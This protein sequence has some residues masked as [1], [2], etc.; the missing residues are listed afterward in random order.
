ML[1]KTK[2]LKVGITDETIESILEYINNAV[3]NREKITIVTPNPEI[4]VYASK[5]EDYKKIINDAE[6][7]LPDGI[8]VFVAL[9]LMG[10]KLQERIPGVDFIEELCKSSREKPLSMGFLGGGS[11][12][13]ERAVDCLKK[14]YPWIN[15]S[16][17]GEEWDISSLEQLHSKHKEIGGKKQKNK[18]KL[19]PNTNTPDS[20]EHT[21]IDILFV[22]FGAPKQ[23][24]WIHRNLDRLPVTAA[25]GVG[26]AFDYISGEVNRAPYMV[27]AMGF[28]WLFR[29]VQQPWRWKRQLALFEFVY[30]VIK[31][32]LE[33]HKEVKS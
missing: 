10:R 2:L 20:Q 12:I 27:R 9:G 17:I 11:G 3:K 4:L 18:E 23:E 13:A 32:Q 15:V 7:A 26:G 21:T 29:L 24:E 6:I 30:L 22:A 1:K 16:F 33:K 5:H 19:A 8:G 25:M 31:E 28:E 14:K